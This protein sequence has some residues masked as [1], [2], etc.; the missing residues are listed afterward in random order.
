MAPFD[1]DFDYDKMTEGQVQGLL[2]WL[3]KQIEK[4]KLDR[5][6]RVPK[7]ATEARAATGRRSENPGHTRAR[8]RSTRTGTNGT[9][10]EQKFT[11]RFR[12][13]IP[14]GRLAVPAEEQV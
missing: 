10:G 6:E 7:Q 4:V 12:L 14:T 9:R 5:A 2:K 13:T 8:N 11:N 3:R 1:E